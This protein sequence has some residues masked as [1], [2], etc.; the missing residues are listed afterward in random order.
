MLGKP[1]DRQ[2]SRDLPLLN[3]P[4]R[5][6]QVWLVLAQ[7]PQIWLAPSQQLQLCRALGHV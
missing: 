2:Q 1:M 7:E 4:V 6:P 5:Q 3:V